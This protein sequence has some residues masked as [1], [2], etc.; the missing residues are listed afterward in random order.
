MG[1]GY[2]IHSLGNW[3]LIGLYNGIGIIYR[4]K[5]SSQLIYI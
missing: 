5:L 3:S 2:Y 1:S 4:A